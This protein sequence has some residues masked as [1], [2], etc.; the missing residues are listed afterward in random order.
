MPSNTRHFEVSFQGDFLRDLILRLQRE[1]GS[2]TDIVSDLENQ[3]VITAWPTA[4][5]VEVGVDAD[6]DMI[7][8]GANGGVIGWIDRSETR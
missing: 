6:G 7:A 2:L 8:A 3:E 5:F 1:I 4:P